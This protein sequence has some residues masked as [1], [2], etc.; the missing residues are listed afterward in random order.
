MKGQPG[1]AIVLPTYNGGKY[2]EEQLM[3]IS[4]QTYYH[5]RIYIR[6]DESKD[7]TMQ[8]I[9]KFEKE[10]ADQVVII[11]DKKGNLGVTRN[12]FE[13]LSRVEED[14]IFLCD[15][16]DIWAKNK[17]SYLMKVMLDVEKANGDIPLLV[18]SDAAIVN[19]NLDIISKSFTKY[20]HIKRQYCTFSNLL[21][22][23]VVQG[24]T[25]V[26]NRK[27][28]ELLY[29]INFYTKPLNILHDHMIALV[30]SMFG[31]IVYI[32]QA[33]ILYRQHERNVFGALPKIEKTDIE[34]WEED[35]YLKYLRK[36]AIA[37]RKIYKDDLSERQMHIVD[38]YCEKKFCYR[39]FIKLKLYREYSYINNI[40]RLIFSEKFC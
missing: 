31:K 12:V 9:E 34:K 25:S 22:K 38:L 40:I 35:N 17:I 30:V 26:F 11:K 24:C 3:S 33:T 8:I 27:L 10:R 6:D 13:I 15:Q 37:F 32:P 7:L 1:V 28:L 5:W 4:K 2:L 36:A 18:H 23:N 20:A 29:K 19:K 16:D 14:Y 39:R 21:H